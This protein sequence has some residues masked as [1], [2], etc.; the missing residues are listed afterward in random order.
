VKRKS[1]CFYDPSSDRRRKVTYQRKVKELAV[2]QHQMERYKQLLGGIIAIIRAGDMDANRDLIH[3]I[4]SGVELSQL[5]AH[6]N[7]G[8]R[9]NRAIQRAYDNMDFLLDGTENL[10][11]PAHIL[12]EISPSRTACHASSAVQ[13]NTVAGAVFAPMRADAPRPRTHPDCNRELTFSHSLSSATSL[14]RPRSHE[15]HFKGIKH[16]SVMH[17]I[18]SVAT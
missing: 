13:R 4:R 2:T 1:I 5:A 11:S 16:S 18:M 6:V 9:A 15:T 17:D 8:C 3:M 7:N 14:T 12:N 10:P